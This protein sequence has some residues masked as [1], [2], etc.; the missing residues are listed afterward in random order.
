[1]PLHAQNHLTQALVEM[2]RSPRNICFK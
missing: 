2:P 1:L